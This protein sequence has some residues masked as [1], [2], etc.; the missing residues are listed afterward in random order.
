MSR[1]DKLKRL[2]EANMLIKI[3]SSYGRRFFYCHSTDC[4]A[5]MSIGPRGHIY[6][7]DNYTRKAIYTAYPHRWSGFS[8]G[9]TMRDLVVA[10]A[11]YVRNGAKLSMHW[12]G[13]DRRGM[14]DGNI[15]GYEA[16]QMELCRAEAAKTAVIKPQAA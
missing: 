4:V 7:H 8:H 10:L 15:W 12:I 2:E 3:I 5:H 16:G 11:E 1:A 13:P 14:T 9:G 6:F